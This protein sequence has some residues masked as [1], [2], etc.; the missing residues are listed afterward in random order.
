MEFSDWGSRRVD[1]RG[2]LMG[3]NG[4]TSE[5]QHVGTLGKAHLA[6][7]KLGVSRQ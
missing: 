6:F 1:K 5:L 7:A 4:G 3:S 2:I